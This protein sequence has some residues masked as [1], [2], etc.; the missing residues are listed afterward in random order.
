MSTYPTNDPSGSTPVFNE[1]LAETPY[2]EATEA[3][4]TPTDAPESASSSSDGSTPKEVAS[5]AKDAAQSAAST[6]TDQA[7][8]VASEVKSQ[9]RDL[10]HTTTSELRDQ[11][12]TQQ[13]RVAAG[14]RTLG[15]ELGSMADG[16]ES[17]G[18]ASELVT[19][20]SK[21]SSDVAAWLDERDPGALFSE[22][23]S[24]AARRP[25]AF[26]AI[27]AGAGIVAG[28]LAKSVA[29]TAAD[30]KSSEG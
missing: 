26:I 9:A 23:K 20:L 10:L 11:A 8:Q 18:V 21:R 7:K 12:A 25:G 1:T 3:L 27:A 2:S 17:S 30:N 4:Y 29:A 19:N 5:T 16:S 15:D 22:V 6:T 14:L 13:Q 24:F 28:R